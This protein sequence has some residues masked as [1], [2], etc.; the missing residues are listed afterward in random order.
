MSKP[1]ECELAVRLAG[2]R[3]IAQV[4]AQLNPVTICVEFKMCKSAYARLPA[5]EVTAHRRARLS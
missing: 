5:I 4:A 2:K 1:T 3:V